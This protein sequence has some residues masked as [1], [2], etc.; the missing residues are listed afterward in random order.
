MNG[1]TS[2]NMIKAYSRFAEI[3][4]RIGGDEFSLNFLPRLLQII[5]KYGAQ[6]RRVLDLA[7]GTGS[8][9]IMLARE[10]L[11]VTGLDLSPYM[12]ERARNKAQAEPDLA[13]TF[14]EGDMRSFTL[15]EPVELITCLF[16]AMNYNL[17]DEDMTATFRSCARAL[18]PGGL[19]VF[20]LNSI[21]SL[22][23]FWGDDVF[24]EDLGDVAYIWESSYDPVTC[25]SALKAI[26][27][28][29]K[30]EFYERFTEMHVERAYPISQVRTWLTEAGFEVLEV[31][32]PHGKPAGEADN[33]HVYVARKRP[34]S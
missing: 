31:I 16:D 1:H 20:D 8:L 24:A 33:R 30:G 27:F 17:A 13:V 9:A 32:T 6:T 26:F 2:E 3:Y 18:V 22:S 10:G 34:C 23:Q 11:K 25:C 7:C 15:A 29:R 19:F 5:A 14:I 4:D 21:N 28:V 12:L